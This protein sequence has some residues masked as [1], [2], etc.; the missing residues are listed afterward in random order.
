MSTAEQVERLR[1]P[2]KSRAHST[3]T[4]VKKP[5]TP[6]KKAPPSK[7]TGSPLD[8]F[9]RAMPRGQMSG[10]RRESEPGLREA[11][12]ARRSQAGGEG[13]SGGGSGPG[14]DRDSKRDPEGE[15]PRTHADDTRRKRS[16]LGEGD[17]TP[18]E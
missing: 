4:R 17:E 18:G 11:Q 8:P 13:R 16:E 14:R 10:T 1:R 2:E 3:M 5:K 12:P 7:L 15:R 9:V 6:V